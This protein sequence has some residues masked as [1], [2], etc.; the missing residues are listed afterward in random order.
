MVLRGSGII[1]G[2]FILRVGDLLKST[3]MFECAGQLK[4]SLVSSNNYY[5]TVLALSGPVVLVFEVVFVD[6]VSI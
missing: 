2:N 4:V 6:V 1:N 5:S 3:Y